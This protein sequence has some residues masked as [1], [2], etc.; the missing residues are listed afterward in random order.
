[1]CL[2]PAARNPEWLDSRLEI[3]DSGLIQWL[4]CFALPVAED[5]QQVLFRLRLD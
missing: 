4:A 3:R 5:L 1:M 2:R